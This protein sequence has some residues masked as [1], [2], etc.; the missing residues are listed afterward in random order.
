MSKYVY[1][2]KLSSERQQSEYD[3]YLEQ[4]GESCE[5]YSFETFKDEALQQNWEFKA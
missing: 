5:T 3:L 4:I 1:L 2:D